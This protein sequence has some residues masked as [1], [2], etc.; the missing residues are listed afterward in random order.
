MSKTWGF[1]FGGSEHGPES[2]CQISAYYRFFSG[3]H[4][5]CISTGLVALAYPTLNTPR[6]DY[7]PLLLQTR[8]YGAIDL[9]FPSL[10]GW[11]WSVYYI[12]QT[13]YLQLFFSA[14]PIASSF[15]A[16]TYPLEHGLV[17]CNNHKTTCHFQQLPLRTPSRLFSYF[18]KPPYISGQNPSKIMSGF[19][20]PHFPTVLFLTSS[21]SP[22]M[23]VSLE[24]S[25]LILFPA[26]CDGPLSLPSAIA[27]PRHTQYHKWRRHIFTFVSHLNCPVPT[28][29]EGLVLSRPIYFE[30][31]AFAYMVKFLAIVVSQSLEK[32]LL[33]R[34]WTLQNLKSPFSW[35]L[36]F[37][38]L[39]KSIFSS[40]VSILACGSTV[41]SMRSFFASSSFGR[42]WVA[43]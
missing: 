24:I 23:L 7:S 21:G 31:S 28:V 20:S 39:C 17:W 37:E 36:A 6:I 26:C 35:L 10:H 4:V 38:P 25:M 29:S 42:S 41:G 14:G 18:Q 15:T 40:V 33:Q 12:I 16:K 13:Q 43:P 32:L 19:M 8:M 1:S 27:I 11:Y 9:S 30:L 3:L 5:F 2:S 22:V 34:P